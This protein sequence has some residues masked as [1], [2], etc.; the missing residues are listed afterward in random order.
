MNDDRLPVS[1]QAHIKLKS[2]TAVR[3]RLIEGRKRIFRNR[4]EGAGAAVAEQ[5]WPG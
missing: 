3:K 2:V 5:K 4:L 1:R